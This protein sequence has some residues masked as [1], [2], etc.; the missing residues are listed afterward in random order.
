MA[1]GRGSGG[2]GSGKRNRKERRVLVRGMKG[3][4]VEEKRGGFASSADGSLHFYMVSK[5]LS[6][7]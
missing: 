1:R 7:V 3:G 2:R 4:V 6:S 5:F